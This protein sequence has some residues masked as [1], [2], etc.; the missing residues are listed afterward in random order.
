MAQKI[1]DVTFRLQKCK[2]ISEMSP[3]RWMS[4]STIHRPGDCL[5]EPDSTPEWDSRPISAE[6]AKAQLQRLPCASAPGPDCLPYSVWKAVDQIG[7]LLAQILEV[8]C[9]E[10][11]IPSAWK[12]S[13]TILLYKKGD[14]GIPS[15]WRPISLQSAIYKIYAGVWAKRLESWATEAGAISPSQKG[16]V[17][18]EE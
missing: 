11:K 4:I 7:S 5:K 17:P 9:R 3:R 1:A 8:C 14:E 6:E 16:L 12:K 13:I 18:G 2:P 10:W 15:N